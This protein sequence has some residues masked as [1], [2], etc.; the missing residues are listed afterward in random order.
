MAVAPGGIRAVAD[1]WQPYTVEI[2]SME[3]TDTPRSVS[4]IV[5]GSARVAR[6]PCG[7]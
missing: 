5:T 2:A 7:P 6:S 4:V 1:K 3:H